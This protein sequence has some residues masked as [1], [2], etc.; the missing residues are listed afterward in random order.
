MSPT[1]D[2]FTIAL[3]QIPTKLNRLNGGFFHLG[4]EQVLKRCGHR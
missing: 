4:H 3:G 2:F 1:L